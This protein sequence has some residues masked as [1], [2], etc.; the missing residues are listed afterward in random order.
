LKLYPEL[1][2]YLP[3]EPLYSTSIAPY[4]S[5]MELPDRIEVEQRVQKYFTGGV[6]MHIFLGEEAD[7]EALANLAKRLIDT[8]IVYWS[9]YTRYNPLQQLRCNVHGDI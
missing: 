6:M 1:R 2:E 3:A 7:P 8:D 5:D 4:Y 9:F